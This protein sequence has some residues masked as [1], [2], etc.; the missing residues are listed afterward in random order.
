M[1]LVSPAIGSS[2]IHL[3]F[4]GFR[5]GNMALQLE[6]QL[7]AAQN[8]LTGVRT[9]PNYR[10]ILI[11]QHGDLSRV[12][13]KVDSLTTEQAGRLLSAVDMDLWGSY[14]EQVKQDIA[15]RTGKDE[16]NCRRLNQD[17]LAAV[18]YLPAWLVARLESDRNRAEVLEH[19]CRHLVQLGLRHPTEK[20][21]GLIL[22]LAFDFHGVA[23]EADKWQ[24][25]VMHK[26]TVQ[27]LLTKPDPPVY[28][29]ALPT[30]VEQ[31]HRALFQAA[32]PNGERPMA[33]QFA[34]DLVGRGRTWPI[35]N[36]HRV[37][38][39]TS[40]PAAT[41][42]VDYYAVGQMVSGMMAGGS[43]LGQ[44]PHSSVPPV[45]TPAEKSPKVLLALEDG[46]V[47]DVPAAV[48]PAE[49]SKPSF[50]LPSKT[51]SDEGAANVAAS[52][53]ALKGAV[54]SQVK[55]TGQ[56]ALKKPAS[57]LQ[58][59]VKEDSLERGKKLSTVMKKPASKVSEKLCKAAEGKAAAKKPPAASRAKKA[60]KKTNQ[61][62]TKA[63]KRMQLLAT[64]PPQIRRKYKDGCG[65]CRWRKECTLSCWRL[66]GFLLE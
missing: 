65:R 1:H 13:A 26:A 44:R 58:A 8:F 50:A 25:T 4:A 17:F 24:Y 52:L 12:F 49:M 45:A 38:A 18:H 66:R 41:Q 3:A 30:D 10:E 40:K 19:L 32:F 21:C 61:K 51:I 23:F 37:A 15:T 54:A 59:Q 43:H 9:L 62:E 64:L 48:P 28:L 31:C 5:F 11:K 36:S 16:A 6:R 57:S 55:G 53:A 46:P 22:A 27:K 56:K 35:R 7:K 20:T 47:E 63:A 34:A 39:Q 42:A 14:A 60:T 29:E 2:E 33:L